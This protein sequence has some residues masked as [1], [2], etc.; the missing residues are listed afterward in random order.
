KSLSILSPVKWG[1]LAM[2]GA[3][4]REFSLSE[5]MLPC[6][7]LLGIGIAGIAIGTSLLNR[8]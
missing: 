1:I 8:E 2:E 7:I 4:W 6:G 3:I 5:M